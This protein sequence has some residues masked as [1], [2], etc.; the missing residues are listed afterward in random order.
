MIR[1]RRERT[2][3]R[4]MGRGAMPTEGRGFRRHIY[5]DFVGRHR[6]WFAVSGAI[7]LIAIGSLVLRGLDLSIDFVGGTSFTLTE[8]T[9]QI[10]G[11]EL[12]DVARDAGA[13]EPRAQIVTEGDEVVGAMVTMAGLEPGSQA[14]IAVEDAL[15]GA[16]GAQEVSVQFVGPTWGDHISN[17]MVQALVVFLLLAAGY[18]AVRLE[19]KM[20]VIAIVALVHDVLLAAGVYSLFQFNVS[21]PTV[22]AFLTILGYSMYDTVIVFDR[23]DENTKK[24]GGPGRRSYGQAVNTSM[25]DVL[26]RSI[27]TTISSTLP[28]LG[29]LV[30]GSQLLGATTL[31]DLALA[32][33]VGMVAGAFSSLFLA[34]P[35]LA[36][37]REREPRL[38]L[39]AQHAA[40]K[41]E[42][43]AEAP[44]PGQDA[45]AATTATD[46]GP[47]ERSAPADTGDDPVEEAEEE[48]PRPSR[49]PGR[50]PGYVRGPGKKPRRKR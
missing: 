30:I 11:P 33:F 28:V 19:W 14:E 20:A 13:E 22:I 40:L 6:T 21:P 46:D 3:K 18:M 7:M 26:W 48:G 12:E 1:R 15:V 32:L 24:L 10:S 49:R 45:D 36:I 50:T 23:V 5:I 29:L 44:V 41:D 42:D 43:A 35:L 39:L 38:A 37:W 4:G 34:G 27:N 9:E 16:T 2:G 25:N 17:R 8:V 31:F 47:E